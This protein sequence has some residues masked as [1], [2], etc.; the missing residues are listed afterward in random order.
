MKTRFF[1]SYVSLLSLVF[2]RTL[3]PLSLPVFQSGSFINASLILAAKRLVRPSIPR[4]YTTLSSFPSF[5]SLRLLPSSLAFR[6]PAGSPPQMLLTFSFI[7]Y[8]TQTHTHTHTP[9]RLVS[10]TLPPSSL[11]YFFLVFFYSRF[12]QPSQRILSSLF[13]PTSRLHPDFH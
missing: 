10:P 4:E 6:Y 2:S 8:F 3:R 1:L 9:A 5:Q 12:G 13:P 11:T 7:F